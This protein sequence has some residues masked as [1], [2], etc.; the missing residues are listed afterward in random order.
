MF[1]IVEVMLNTL[2]NEVDVRGFA[3]TEIICGE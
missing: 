3:W 1:D 2:L